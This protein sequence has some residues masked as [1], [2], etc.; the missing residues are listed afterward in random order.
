[1]PTRRHRPRAVGEEK[2]RRRRCG[3]VFRRLHGRGGRRGC[4][5]HHW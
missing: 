3:D 4:H 2:E 1:M 5:H